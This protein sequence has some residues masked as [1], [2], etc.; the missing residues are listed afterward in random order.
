MEYDKEKV[1]EFVLALLYLNQFTERGVPR[2]WKG[3]DW[4]ALNLLHEQ[5]YISDPK[6]K[7]KSV[8]FTE[9]GAKRAEQLFSK[10]FASDS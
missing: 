10:H 2:A 9:E 6:S 3:F 5:G 8:V 4:D 1:S 7:A